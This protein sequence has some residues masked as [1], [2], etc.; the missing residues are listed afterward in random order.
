NL[1]GIMQKFIDQSISTNINYD[2][3]RFYNNKIPMEQLLKDLLMAYK[4]GIKTLYYQNT[5][6]G[7]K[8]IQNENIL[9]K[10]SICNNGACTL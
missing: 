8:D 7:A 6:D 2:P 3:T 5:R 1:I 10:N 4:L 9:E